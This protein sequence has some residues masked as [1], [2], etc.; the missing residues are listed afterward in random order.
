ML[1]V[2]ENK[3][4]KNL[5]SY[6]LK[7]NSYRNSFSPLQTTR[8]ETPGVHC[9]NATTFQLSLSSYHKYYSPA[10]NSGYSKIQLFLLNFTDFSLISA[11]LTEE[12]QDQI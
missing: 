10:C 11:K 9:S 8:L 7:D 6:N 12:I 1:A 3:R 4:E 5:R 2:S